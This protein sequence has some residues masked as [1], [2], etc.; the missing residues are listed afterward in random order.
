MS[1]RKI[2]DIPYFVLELHPV[3]FRAFDGSMSSWKDSQV[4][5]IG[6]LTGSKIRQGVRGFQVSEYQVST[7]KKSHP[8]N[9]YLSTKVILTFLF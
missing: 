6:L 7:K 5:K 3:G 4:G 2:N 1:L 9:C 8:Y